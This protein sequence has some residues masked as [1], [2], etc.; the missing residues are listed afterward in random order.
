MLLTKSI[1]HTT[2]GYV[3]KLAE[4]GIHT[5]ADLL[6]YFPKT[7]RDKSQVINQFS[8]CTIREPNTVSATIDSLFSERTRSGKLLIKMIIKDSVGV[9]SEAVWFNRAFLLTQFRQNDSVILYGK[10]KYEYGK[11]SFLNADIELQ[12]KMNVIESVYSDCNYIPGHWF[13]DKIPL[14]QAYISDIPDALPEKIRLK[15][16]FKHTRQNIASLHFPASAT[17]FQTAKQALAYEELFA[18]QFAGI[19]KKLAANAQSLHHT[20]SVPL[21]ADYVKELLAKLPYALTGEQK[22]ALFQILKDMEKDYA[23]NRLLQ[24]DV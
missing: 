9:R 18:F 8:L 14:L 6:H 24:G 19:Q 4:A 3:K 22:I 17:D 20:F 21:D 1:L 23:M 15:K 5:V 16:G 7:Y 10:P 12:S 13:T 11:L 2:D